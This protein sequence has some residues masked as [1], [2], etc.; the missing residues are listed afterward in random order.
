MYKFWLCFYVFKHKIINKKSF[1]KLF[2]VLL[3]LYNKQDEKVSK[4]V[5]VYPYPDFI[6]IIWE[7]IW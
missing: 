7:Y 2:Y 1:P 4:S 3:D 5:Y 6:F